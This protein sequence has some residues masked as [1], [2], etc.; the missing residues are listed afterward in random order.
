[1][2]KLIA[3]FVS[4]ILLVGC[5]KMSV[6]SSSTSISVSS[7]FVPSS[8]SSMV[9]ENS[10]LSPATIPVNSSN[11]IFTYSDFIVGA[12]TEEVTVQLLEILF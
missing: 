3:V 5:S 8:S 7:S 4:V 9:L 11:L 10:S 1:M 2:K 6:D 12:D